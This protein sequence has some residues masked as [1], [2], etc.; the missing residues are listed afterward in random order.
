MH[1]I[2]L[3]RNGGFLAMAAAG[4]G[5]LGS[6]LGLLGLIGPKNKSAAG[7]AVITVSFAILA[8]TLGLA[9]AVYGKSRVEAALAFVGPADAEV[10]RQ[11]GYQEAQD[12][13]WVGFAAALL[14]L[15]LGTG[16]ILAA[17]VKSSNDAP[18]LSALTRPPEE[19][20]AGINNVALV[21]A[22]LGAILTA[23][24]FAMSRLPLPQNKYGLDVEDR[25]GWALA[26]ALDETRTH[27][28]RGCNQ[29][30]TALRQLAERKREAPASLPW[31]EPASQCVERWLE[32]EPMTPRLSDEGMWTSPMLHDPKLRSAVEAR[33]ESLQQR[34][35]L[36]DAPVKEPALPPDLEPDPGSPPARTGALSASEIGQ[37][38]RRASPQMRSCYESQLKSTPKLA[39]KII[40]KFTVGSDGRVSDAVDASSPAFPNASTKDCVLAKFKA[41]RF[42]SHSGDKVIVK[43]PIVFKAN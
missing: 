13:S 19:S 35:P 7:L 23:G 14:P 2:D 17:R 28:E 24:A 42:P 10:V 12:A 20:T 27:P 1:I 33:R 6:L 43:Y 26:R 9:G 29:L 4:A 32:N 39:G 11:V 25:E 31:R 30:D 34:K 22:A 18:V 41:L 36:N 38:V 5:V 8:A 3:I 37:V 21:F 15:L 16:V 40:V